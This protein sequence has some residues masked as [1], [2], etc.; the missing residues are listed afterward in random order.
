MDGG[1]PD[2]VPC[3]LNFYRVD[4]GFWGLDDS[5]DEPIVDVQF[6]RFPESPAIEELRRTA[7]PY[8]GDTRL[9]S[10]HQVATYH[11]W[12][13][14][15]ERPDGENPLSKAR[16]LRELEEFPFPTAADPP[17][18][19][20]L[21]SQVDELHARGLAAG[22][23]LPH[24]GGELFE[25]AWRLRGLENFLF[26][27]IE[28]PDWAHCMLDRLTAL[29]ISNAK[30]LAMAGVDVLSLDDDVGMPCSMMMSPETWRAF[31]K[32]RMAKIIAEARL[33]KPDLRILF[34]S[35]GWFEPIVED[36]ID[37]GVQAINPLQP[38]TMGA[39]RIRERFGP[40][41]AL[42]GGIGSQATFSRSRPEDIRQLVRRLIESVGTAGLILCPAYDIDEPDVPPENVAV[43]LEA[44][45][46]FGAPVQR[47]A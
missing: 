23:N 39:A 47:M 26:D 3:A 11:G 46:E 45:R 34:H 35:D 4:P 25:A 30:A 12:R 17:D 27:L 33:V 2:R 9:G 42:W 7:L 32:S 15:P 18:P 28:R 41:L 10:T 16:S 19:T 40:K 24:L 29:A 36:L 1:E 37:I 5:G 8:S 14:D 20:G 44:A 21:R 31:F 38:E 6:V 22:G 43:F 13:Y